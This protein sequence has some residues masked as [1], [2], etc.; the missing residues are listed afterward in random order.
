MSIRHYIPLRYQSKGLNI[1]MSLRL[2]FIMVNKG[3]IIEYNA[4]RQ[5]DNWKKNKTA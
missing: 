5:R 4:D 2:D 1:K 3:D